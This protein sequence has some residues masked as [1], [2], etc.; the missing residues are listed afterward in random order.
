MKKR[1]RKKYHKKY[2]GMMKSEI[3]F[4]LHWTKLCSD[5][6]IGESTTISRKNIRSVRDWYINRGIFYYNIKFMIQRIPLE[7]WVPSSVRDKFISVLIYSEEF[8][9]IKRIHTYYQSM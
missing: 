6:I 3:E 2:I 7:E 1:Y 5:F 4:N 8:P 9:T